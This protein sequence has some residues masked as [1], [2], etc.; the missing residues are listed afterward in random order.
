MLKAV[1]D[2]CARIR[3][4][5][6]EVLSKD[7]EARDLRGAKDPED[8]LPLW[9]AAAEAG[10][11]SLVLPPEFG[12]QGKSYLEAMRLLSA[13]GEGCRDNGLL[14]ALNGQLWAMQMSIYEF[15]ND[16]A[17]SEWLPRMANGS[18]ICAHAVTEIDSGSDVTGIRMK[19]EKID[20]GYR[21]NGE[22]VWI[23]MAPAAH[24]AQVF[25]V[26][27]P[28]K[29][30]WGMSAF[31][32]DLSL[33]GITRSEP[34]AKAGHRTV[35]AGALAFENVEIPENT[36]LGREGAG[37]AIFTQ[38]IAWE[39]C[40]IFSSH[41]GA[42]KR[43]LDETIAFARTRAPNGVPIINHQTVA[44]RLADMQLRYETA[45]LMIENAAREMD[46]KRERRMTA[47]LVKI[48]VAEA[49]LENA[50]E[51]QRIRASAGYLVGETERMVRDMAGTITLGGTSD[52][53]RRVIAA[54]Q[55]ASV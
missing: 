13:L 12:G 47:P 27:D 22:K 35:P 38:S 46:E 9:N 30:A 49:L 55:K 3:T 41:V 19:A 31:L 28:E 11:L 25:A 54:F 4:L 37:H 48:A 45:R 6:A 24:V 44:N 23:G 26:T 36:L 29:G 2:E 42:M 43:Q 20:G 53:Q 15:G 14:L 21:L 51:A 32:V 34:Y 5:G 18:V 33:P 40:F 17:K 39:R 10:V 52:I 1:E 16:A 50:L 8:W 7:V